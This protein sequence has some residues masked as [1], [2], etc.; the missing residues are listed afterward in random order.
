MIPP[1]T[2]THRM[3]EILDVRFRLWAL[4]RHKQNQNIRQ[5]MKQQGCISC[6][7]LL[8]IVYVTGSYTLFC[9]RCKPTIAGWPPG[10]WIRTRRKTPLQIPA[11]S[12]RR[13]PFVV[14]TVGS[15]LLSDDCRASIALSN[16]SQTLWSFEH[17]CRSGPSAAGAAGMTRSS[18]CS[19]RMNR[20]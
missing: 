20:L 2:Q 18:A 10:D 3:H 13:P 7:A 1:L 9:K 6:H 16:G 14:L 4:A 17:V 12:A 19:S 15:R 8:P 11:A 5:E